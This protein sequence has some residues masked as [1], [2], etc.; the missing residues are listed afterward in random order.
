ME[1]EK[2]KDRISINTLTIDSVTGPY[3]TVDKSFLNIPNDPKLKF[4]H[5]MVFSIEEMCYAFRAFIPENIKGEDVVCVKNHH[6]GTTG[7]S[8]GTNPC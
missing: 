1:W 3:D 6:L 7:T 8:W 5:C 4:Q 2:E